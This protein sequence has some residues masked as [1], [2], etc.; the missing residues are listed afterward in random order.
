[1]VP[2]WKHYCSHQLDLHRRQKWSRSRYWQK[3]HSKYLMSYC[4][5]EIPSVSEASK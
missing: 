1:M 3:M 5:L 2:V 4:G